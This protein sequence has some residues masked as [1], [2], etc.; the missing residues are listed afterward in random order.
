MNPTQYVEAIALH[1]Q[2]TTSQSLYPGHIFE[3]LAVFLR[4]GLA[5]RSLKLSRNGG[6]PSQESLSFS[7]LYTLDDSVGRKRQVFADAHECVKA[8]QKD[9]TGSQSHILFLK[10]YPS[11]EWLAHIG[12][13]CLTDPE[14]FNS[15]LRF[16]WRRNYFSLPSLPSSS[17]EIIRLRIATIGS[18]DANNH[19]SDQRSVDKLRLDGTKAMRKYN[20]ELEAATNL[21]QG[22]SIVRGYAA[23]DETHF[24]IEQE[25]SICLNYVEKN[26]IGKSCGA[27]I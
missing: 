8:I 10:G 23:L 18:R 19:E 25:I 12:A 20:N 9:T 22:D 24:I 1:S 27:E 2:R 16:R 7:T 5:A 13:L 17:D 15:H 21:N 4:K 3:D 11:P 14:Y 6:V 26:W